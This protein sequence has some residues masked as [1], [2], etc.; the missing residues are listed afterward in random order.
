MAL[1]KNTKA[2]DFSLPSTSGDLFKLSENFKGKS[3][4]IF[5]YPKDQTKGCTQE[6]C[7]FR[8]NF[9]VFS[10]L[11]IPIVGISRDSI[12]SHQEFKKM[13][14][15]PFELLCDEDGSVCKQYKALMPLIKMP[16]R[17]TYLLNAQHEIVAVHE[18]LFDGPAH[19]KA[20][21]EEVKALEK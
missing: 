5:F 8:D 4:L 20:M 17:I 16:K 21:M 6:V 13:H 3:A 12:A 7:S 9:S 10:S 18:G 14:R 2:P 11:E 1:Q 19:V 15:L